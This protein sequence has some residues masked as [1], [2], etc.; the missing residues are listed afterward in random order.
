MKITIKIECDTIIEFRGHLEMLRDQIK[1]KVK[2]EKLDHFHE[3]FS[4]ADN[5]DDN[6][7]YGT[8]EVEI[9]PS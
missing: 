4:N 8:H 9:I 6:N 3:E 2:S 1:K 5:L 7:C